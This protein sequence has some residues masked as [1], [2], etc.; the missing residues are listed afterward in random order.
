MDGDV[1]LIT[2][3]AGRWALLDFL[4][5]FFATY[6]PI[7]IGLV[8]L[9][10][11]L[12][13][14]NRRYRAYVFFFWLFSTLL[15]SGVIEPLINFLFPRPRPFVTYELVPLIPMD[16]ANPSFPSW[17]AVFLFTLATVVFLAMSRKWGAW[18]YI[19]ATLIGAARVFVGVHY[20]LDIIVGALIGFLIPV[21]VQLFLP[22]TDK[23]KPKT[24]PTEEVEVGETEEDG[25]NH[26]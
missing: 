17:H 11:L 6:V 7:I 20:P 10:V 18:L 24:E 23:P 13:Q 12:T 1:Q 5:V 25:L 19:L 21:L 2:Q 26:E 4:G 15:T 16:S 8:F 14:K 22:S 9:I 3:F